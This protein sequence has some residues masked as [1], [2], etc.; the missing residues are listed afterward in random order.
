MFDEGLN[1]MILRKNPPRF[2][3]CMV[4]GWER[5]VLGCL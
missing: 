1:V 4:F 3:Q 2:G 5:E